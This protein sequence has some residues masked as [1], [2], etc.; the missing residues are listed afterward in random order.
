MRTLPS[1]LATHMAS[2]ATTLC[3]AWRVTRSDGL[4]TGFTDH[5]RDLVVDGVTCKAASGIS[6]SQS[7]LAAGLAVTGAEVS[8]ALSHDALSEDDLAAGL[9]DGASIDLLL[10]NWQDPGQHLLLRRG[11]IGEVRAQDGVFTAEIRSLSD[12]LNQTRGRLLS[13]TCDADLGDARCGVD[14]TLPAHGANATVVAVEG[15][16]SLR[17]SG[18]STFEKA[19]FARGRAR[20]SSGANAGFVTEVKAHLVDAE[21]VL[22][23]LWQR[24]TFA[25]VEG[26]V[27][28]LTAGC[29]KQFSTCRDRFVNALNFRG[30]PHMPG[31]DFVI[32]VAIPGEGGYDGSLME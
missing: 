2:G 8:G 24:P 13:S 7:T 17:V 3:H 32:S 14:L 27:I 31:N 21:G 12:G 23:R 6:G 1:A 18:L 9:Y 28:V 25:V 19:A 20:F 22:L 11:T 15:A 4:V 5:D 30:F 26:D 16:L 29:D 10:V